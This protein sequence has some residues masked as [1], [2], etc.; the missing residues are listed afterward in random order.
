VDADAHRHLTAEPV[1]NGGTSLYQIERYDEAAVFIGLDVGK[2]EHHAV[3]LSR[4]G[5]KLYDKPLP[6]TERGITEVLAAACAPVQHA[7]P[8]GRFIESSHPC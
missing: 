1:R 2:S 7:V 8:V 6:N 4:D 3:A 5:R